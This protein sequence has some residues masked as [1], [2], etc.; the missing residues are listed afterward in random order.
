MSQTVIYGLFA[1]VH[2]SAVGP[3]DLQALS[4]QARTAVKAYLEALRPQ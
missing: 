3:P 4:L 1:H 2:I